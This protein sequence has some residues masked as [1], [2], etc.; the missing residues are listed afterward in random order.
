MERNSG[1]LRRN[2]FDPVSNVNRC[3]WSNSRHE[4]KDQ[5]GD[6]SNESTHG[7][8]PAGVFR[9]KAGRYVR[10]TGVASVQNR[11]S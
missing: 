1:R 4:R 11:A 6:C 9:L 5:G 10:L 2:E 8:F 7:W 3:S